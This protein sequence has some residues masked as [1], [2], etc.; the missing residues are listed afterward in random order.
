[1]FAAH[2]GSEYRKAEREDQAHSGRLPALGL[3]GRWALES[4]DLLMQI[5]DLVGPIFTHLLA[6]GR[7]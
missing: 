5:L 7:G 4:L 2:Q 3:F 1:M 6:A